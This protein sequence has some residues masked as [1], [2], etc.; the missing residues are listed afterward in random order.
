MSQ[1]ARQ[2]PI[3]QLENMHR[4][5][6]QELQALERHAYLTPTEQV[7]ARVLKKLKLQTKDRITRQST[8]PPAWSGDRLR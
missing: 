5:L 4:E 3:D 2:L 7:R 6:K 1:A 8:P